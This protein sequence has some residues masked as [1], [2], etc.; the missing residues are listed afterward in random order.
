MAAEAISIY[1]FTKQD[2]FYP[3]MQE[4]VDILYQSY[5][6]NIEIFGYCS[7]ISC[8]IIFIC[9]LGIVTFQKLKYNKMK[10][11]YKVRVRLEIPENR[12]S[13]YGS[14]SELSSDGEDGYEERGKNGGLTTTM[15]NRRQNNN[16]KEDLSNP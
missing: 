7:I 1:S 8:S 4:K 14:Y 16:Q 9:F 6:S 15:Y 3:G 2:C 12:A 13:S 11:R 10:I 5:V